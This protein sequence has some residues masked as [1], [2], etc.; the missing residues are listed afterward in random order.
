MHDRE[1]EEAGQVQGKGLQQVPHM[2]AAK[3]IHEKVRHMPNML[4]SHGTEGLYPRSNEIKLVSSDNQAGG[5]REDVA[6][7]EEKGSY[8][9]NLAGV[10]KC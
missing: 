3:G 1:G 2:R 4:Q 9:P 10:R 6:N 8:D 5:E 7:T